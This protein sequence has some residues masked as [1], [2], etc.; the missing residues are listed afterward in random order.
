MRRKAKAIP[1][2]GHILCVRF[3]LYPSIGLLLNAFLVYLSSKKASSSTPG[4]WGGGRSRVKRCAPQLLTPQ[5]AGVLVPRT[6]TARGVW[7]MALGL[8]PPTL[9]WAAPLTPRSHPLSVAV[10][11]H[12]SS[13]PKKFH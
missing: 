9:A 7:A 4:K 1:T 11:G 8:H 3:F 5:A 6:P 2:G 13:F 12:F 10:M